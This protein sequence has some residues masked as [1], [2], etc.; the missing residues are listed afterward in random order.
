MA[1]GAAVGGW[2][3]ASLLGSHLAHLDVLLLAA[4]LEDLPDLLL[5]VRHRRDDEQPVDD[6]EDDEEVSPKI[7][8]PIWLPLFI[9]EC[10]NARTAFRYLDIHIQLNLLYRR[11]PAIQELS[12]LINP[13]ALCFNLTLKDSTIR[14]LCPL[15]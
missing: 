1:W 3:A 8:S 7:T 12:K 9:G 5:R 14:L 10:I 11:I 15:N 4:D 6:A 13:L 2:A